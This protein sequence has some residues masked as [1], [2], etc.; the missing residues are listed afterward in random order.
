LPTGTLLS[1]P[2]RICTSRRPQ[3]FFDQVRSHALRALDAFHLAVAV[4]M[5]ANPIATADRVTA[6]VAGE[7]GFEVA[8]F[9]GQAP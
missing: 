3:H 1:G 6:A 4:A 5:R 8:D 7:L 2:L 9:R